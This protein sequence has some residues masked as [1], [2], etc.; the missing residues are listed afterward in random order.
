[1]KTVD[2]HEAAAQLSV[3]VDAVSRGEEIV[4]VRD[5]RPLARLV[6]LSQAERPLGFYPIAFQSDLAAPTDEGVMGDFEDV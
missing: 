6:G 5:G 1:M 2:I 4:L 3:L